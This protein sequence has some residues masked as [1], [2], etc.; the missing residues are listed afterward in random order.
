M[1]RLHTLLGSD[2][3]GTSKSI[4]LTAKSYRVVGLMGNFQKKSYVRTWESVVKGRSSYGMVVSKRFYCIDKI[5][6]FEIMCITLLI[7][8]KGIFG[9]VFQK[10]T[11]QC[12][13]QVLVYTGSGW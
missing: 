3:F 12:S 4:R 13:T 8:T 11:Q 1:V 9:S 10:Y 6:A 7:R 5:H 2:S